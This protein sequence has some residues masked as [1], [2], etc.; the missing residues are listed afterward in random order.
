MLRGCIATS[1][2]GIRLAASDNLHMQ[3]HGDEI[4]FLSTVSVYKDFFFYQK[5]KSSFFLNI[6]MDKKKQSLIHI[7]KLTWHL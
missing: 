3:L 2:C 1:W 4:F 5:P 7:S 6:Q